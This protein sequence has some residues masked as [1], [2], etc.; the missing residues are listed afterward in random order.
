M[1][2]PRPRLIPHLSSDIGL[3]PIL[4][5]IFAFNLGSAAWSAVPGGVGPQCCWDAAQSTAASAPS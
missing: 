5:A 1:H 2:L 3:T 4:A